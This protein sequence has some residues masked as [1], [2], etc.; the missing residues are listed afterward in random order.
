MFDIEESSNLYLQSMLDRAS[1]M[2]EKISLYPFVKTAY[3]D[4]LG[5]K[6][7]F[8]EEVDLE[9]QDIFDLFIRGGAI[10]RAGQSKDKEESYI[11]VDPIGEY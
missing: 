8:N 2:A 5:F 9:G 3:I 6:I 1:M 10:K 7:E 4:G 11:K